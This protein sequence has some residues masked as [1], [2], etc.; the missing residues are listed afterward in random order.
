MQVPAKAS[1][2]PVLL[3]VLAPLILLTALAVVAHDLLVDKGMWWHLRQP[4][5]VEGGIEALTLLALLAV[6]AWRGQRWLTTVAIL[7]ALVYLRRHNG[8]L[9]LLAGLFCVEAWHA[10]GGLI[11]AR[12]GVRT[13][14]VEGSLRGIVAGAAVWV[15][16]VAALSLLSLATPKILLGVLLVAGTTAIAV[17]RDLL[18]LRLLRW[19]RAL[20]ALERA[21]LALLGAWLL[22]LI[23]R[24]ANVLAHDTIWY[25]GQSD[26]L[27]SPDGS[28]FQS[29]SLVA[30]VHYFPKLWEIAL[31]P[32][33][34][35][36]QLR[37]QVGV[38]IALLGVLLTA[39]WQIANRLG[40]ARQ[41]RWPLL[42]ILATLA[43]LANTALTLKSDTLCVVFMTIACLHLLSWFQ[44]RTTDA[45]AWAL[46]SAALACSTKLTA[47]PYVATTLIVLGIHEALRRHALPLEPAIDPFKPSEPRSATL[48][49]AGLAL[50]AAVV[51]L[52]R[53]WHLT[54]VPTI[55]PD[56]VLSI[57]NALG[58]HIAE[59][60]GTLDWTRAQVWSDVPALVRDWLFA[61]ST[62][63]KMPIS[64]I[65]NV[66]AIMALLA[67]L[68]AAL[69][70]RP[71]PGETPVA[72]GRALLLVLTLT[73]LALAVA[74]RYHSRGSDG[75]YF[76]LPIVLANMLALRACAVRF[77]RSTMAARSL[78]LTLFVV[79]LAHATHSFISAGWSPP[80]TRTLDLVFDQSPLQ[81]GEWRAQVLRRAG[82]TNIAA[83]LGNQ[84]A[85]A[86]GIGFDPRNE[87][88]HVMLPIAMEEIRNIGYSRPAYTV[89]GTAL[90][91]Y[92][93]R[94]RIDHLV[95]PVDDDPAIIG[96]YRQAVVAAGWAR[97]IDTGGIL[98]SR[99]G[100]ITERQQ[101]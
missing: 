63:P 55:G 1:W 28:I 51:L 85:H 74:W 68:A 27:L 56:A 33:T 20:P 82:L 88:Y 3:T 24:T 42:W 26:R 52:I 30:P 21:Q 6:A 36:D 37:P 11:R 58:L 43:A 14:R 47:I 76:I 84:P 38:A 45:L 77:D 48:V 83:E 87:Q 95:L 22:V 40:I 100:V 79:G 29:L 78:A 7:G 67:A 99:P 57:W 61:P 18:C 31:L 70:M 96:N 90:L 75:N 94:L 44:H 92:M 49:G 15:L 86:R 10:T 93:D 13:S 101:R 66:W 34:A 91:A 16:V 46:A 62:M 73:G 54:G 25:L 72:S 65:G 19:M 59:P 9:P 69:G 53:T 98:Y 81:P 80:G 50:L 8:E 4:A 39:I 60:A 97:L 71:V 64:W 41:W 23:A 17:H 35:L 32:W 12:L 2:H 89:D 5:S